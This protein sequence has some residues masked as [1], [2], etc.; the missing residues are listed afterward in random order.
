MSLPKFNTFLSALVVLA[1]SVPTAKA[2][3]DQAT[4]ANVDNQISAD[5]P[6]PV[7]LAMLTEQLNNSS[8]QV[9]Q[10]ATSELIDFGL[11]SVPSLV[12]LLST[13]DAEANWRSKSSLLEVTRGLSDPAD[14]ERMFLILDLAMAAGH[15]D[16]A[17][18]DSNL[19]Q[20]AARAA[21]ERLF[22]RLSIQEGI[23]ATKYP[24]FDNRRIVQG[25][26][27]INGN[28]QV[29]IDNG[30]GLEPTPD[31]TSK[32][33]ESA[34][35]SA[36]VFATE[37]LVPLTRQ[38]CVADSTTL[39]SIREKIVAAG[40]P[41]NLSDVSDMNPG[42]GMSVNVSDLAGVE[43]LKKLA[44]LTTRGAPY[45]LALNEIQL[46]QERF[47]L[48]KDMIQKMAPTTLILE[49][50]VITQDQLEILE[51]LVQPADRRI[52][53]TGRAM[54]GVRANSLLTE[55]SPALV[56]QVTPGSGADKAGII[57][58]DLIKTVNG[59]PVRNFEHLRRMIACYGPGDEVTLGVE[60]QGRG[61]PPQDVPTDDEGLLLLKVAL[62]DFQL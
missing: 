55:N 52:S 22:E 26:I 18:R 43:T 20:D 53:I 34:G 16:I 27:I 46:D 32:E 49:K 8:Y 54:L 37:N 6:D 15:D 48:L 61:R 39:D 19:R 33:T 7:R 44:E 62:T 4:P 51:N 42:F 2:Q 50:C 60:R 25:Q 21:A 14:Q 57:V 59:T 9:R 10:A 23:M 11:Q 38:I 17:P 29:I 12:E 45:S 24:I 31:S 40:V 1:V 36:V 56:S 5:A 13:N 47:T 30:P 35:E 3:Q 58:S 41:L 28:R